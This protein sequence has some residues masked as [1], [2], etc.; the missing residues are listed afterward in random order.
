MDDK[1]LVVRFISSGILG[2][3]AGRMATTYLLFIT[4]FSILAF[5]ANAVVLRIQVPAV[6]R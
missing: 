2:I 5:I 3:R 1:V 6:T 4:D